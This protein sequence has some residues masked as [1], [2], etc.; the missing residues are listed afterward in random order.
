MTLPSVHRIKAKYLRRLALNQLRPEVALK[1]L[2]GEKIKIKL[3]NDN[4]VIIQKTFFDGWTM[5]AVSARSKDNCLILEIKMN[6]FEF[7]LPHF[8]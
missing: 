2:R 5:I 8:L 4:H 6:A 1:V 3:R 7:G